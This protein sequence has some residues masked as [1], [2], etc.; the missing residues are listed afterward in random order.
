MNFFYK[1]LFTEKSEF[2]NEDINAYLSQINILIL[3]KEQ[4]QTCEGPITEYELLNALKSMPN[5]KSPGND[6][7]TKEFYETFWEEIKIPLRN[8]ITISYQN[9]ELSTSLRQLRPVVIKLIEKKDKDK[10]L[11]KNWRP[12]SLLNVDTKLISKVLAERLKKILPSLISK[13]QTAY[14][15][16]R[17]ISE[18]GR[19]ISDILEISDNLKVKGFLMTLDM[20]KAFDSVNHLF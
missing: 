12:I 17:F 15:K 11:I 13:N 18:G 2:Q 5:N 14:V 10:K 8:I 19:L 1:N 6:D 4:S 3:T 9:G 20:E 7:L 16:G